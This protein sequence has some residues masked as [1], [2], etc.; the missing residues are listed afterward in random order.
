MLII[1]MWEHGNIIKK[2]QETRVWLNMMNVYSTF[3]SVF[4]LY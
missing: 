2:T 3:S 1:E 4:G